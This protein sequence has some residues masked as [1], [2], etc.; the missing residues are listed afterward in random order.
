MDVKNSV[1]SFIAENMFLNGQ[2]LADDAS[3]L[4]KGVLDSTGIFELIAFLEG[5]FK[6]QVADGEMM[7]ENFDS[8]N[9]IQAYV[10][11]KRAETSG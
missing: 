6:I 5:T 2:E 11:R 4:D 10:D 8:L 3:F 1:R 7:P 9:A